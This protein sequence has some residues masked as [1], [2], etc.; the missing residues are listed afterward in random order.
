MRWVRLR[1][2]LPGPYL[3]R[4]MVTWCD[5]IMARIRLRILF[6]SAEIG[7]WW[8]EQKYCIDVSSLQFPETY[9][10][11]LSDRCYYYWAIISIQLICYPSRLCLFWGGVARGICYWFAFFVLWNVFCFGL[12]NL[13]SFRWLSQRRHLSR[14]VST[15]CSFVSCEAHEGVLNTIL[16]YWLYLFEVALL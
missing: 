13:N 12:R 10:I 11:D 2:I 14:Q 15:H 9:R 1:G 7:R 5:I 6:R 4:R 16:F 3:M 8:Y